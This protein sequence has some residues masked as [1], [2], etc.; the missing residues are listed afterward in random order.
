MEIHAIE[1]SFGEIFWGTWSDRTIAEKVLKIIRMCIDEG[2]ELR[3]LEI[4]QCV[5]QLRAGL[6]PYKIEITRSVASGEILTKEISL[7]WPPAESEGLV[8]ER[9]DYVRYFAWAK[10]QNEAV[11]KAVLAKRPNQAQTP[12][13]RATAW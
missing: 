13:V 9:E 4:N 2:A 1:D 11:Q 8:E 7:T 5:E 6:L 12:K 3:S 10:T